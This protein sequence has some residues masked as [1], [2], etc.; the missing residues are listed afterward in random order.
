MQQTE[1]YGLN[2][3]ELSDRIRMEDFNADNLKIAEALA[4]KLG[5]VEILSSVHQD[6]GS[7]FGIQTVLPTDWNDWALFGIFLQPENLDRAEDAEI[8]AH[9]GSEPLC[10]VKAGPL[11]ILMFPWY[12]SSRQVRYFYAAD[13]CGLGTCNVIYQKMI[14]PAFSMLDS[15]GTGFGTSWLV[16]FVIK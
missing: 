4:G 15:N 16:R 5:K 6:L 2:Q 9:A 12:D 13:T 14:P 7:T 8:W 10:T 3:W 1:Q 11:A